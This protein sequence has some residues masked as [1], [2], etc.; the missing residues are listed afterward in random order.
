MK[1]S[2]VF[3]ISTF[4][5]TGCDS[6]YKYIFLPAERIEYTLVPDKEAMNALQDSSY[7][8]GKN[9]Q[10]VGY[11][12]KDW[13]IE[14]RYMTDYQLNTFEFPEESKSGVYSGNPFTYGNWVDPSLG[15]SPKT[16]FGF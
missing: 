13:K 1:L 11:D 7:F 9:G 15:Y 2:A 16:V 12:A 14:L 8:I 3:L 5:F 4:L 10:M 6:V